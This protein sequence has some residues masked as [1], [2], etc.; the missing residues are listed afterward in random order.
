MLTTVCAKVQH[1]E[2]SLYGKAW[3][4]LKQLRKFAIDH[5]DLVMYEEVVYSMVR[6]MRNH[7]DGRQIDRLRTADDVF[8]NING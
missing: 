3:E 1:L 4:S 7:M 5:R 6:M 2:E 8:G